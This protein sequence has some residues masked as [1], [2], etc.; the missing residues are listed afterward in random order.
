MSL[1]KKIEKKLRGVKDKFVDDIIPN[2]F[3]SG[4]KM[5]KTIRNLI[6]NELADVAV[7]LAP[8][9]APFNAPLAAA[10]RG[11]GRFDQRGSISDALKQAAATY[12]GGKLVGMIPGT[13]SY[14][15]KGFEGAK[16]LGSDAMSGITSIFKGGGKNAANEILK[17]SPKGMPDFS[18]MG[19]GGGAV[20]TGGSKIFDTIKSFGGK[21]KDK[22]LEYFL[23]DDKKFQM[24]DIGRFLGDPGKTIPLTM[25]ATYIKEKFFP[26]EDQDSFDAKFAEAMRKRGENV[27]SYLRRSGPFDPRRDPTKNPY[28]QD[29]IDQFA[30]DLT[31]EYRNVAADGGIMNIPRE[32]YLL[33]GKSI[34]RTVRPEP[35]SRG[36]AKKEITPDDI[37]AVFKEKFDGGNFFGRGSSLLPKKV[38]ATFTPQQA[39]P[40]ERA[41]DEEVRSTIKE[42]FENRLSGMP[43]SFRPEIKNNE[44]IM[45]LLTKGDQKGLDALM[46]SL[47]KDANFDRFRAATG[48]RMNYARGSEEEEMMMA[49]APDP[50]DE[51]NTVM[52][53]IAMEEFGRPLKDLTDDEIIQIEEMFEEM[54]GGQPLPEDPTKPINPF[55]PKP[56]GPALPDKL[57]AFMDDDYEREFMRLVGEFMEQ[58]FTQE[59]AIE[60]AR[61]ELARIGSKFMADGGRV[62]YARGSDTPEENAVQAAGIEGLDLNINPKGVT[63]LD[64]RE[65][66]G[67]IPPVGVKEKED[68][69]PAMLSNNE[70]VFTADAVRGMGD[71]DV[72]KGAE[73][74]YSMMKK[75]ENGGRV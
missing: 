34:A 52:E 17:G 47:L 44:E 41:S 5:K 70:F 1:F 43:A 29:E 11:I 30:D 26:D 54:S 59:E 19:T 65:T 74:M 75:L 38:S 8:F 42:F 14:F 61:N 72:D 7:D 27:G 31:I 16:A 73:R 49:S 20:E 69:I 2:E 68:D 22:G 36:A 71:G 37:M 23:G 50:M 40:A 33:G 21:A 45:E 63:E 51:R 57:M 64:M 48:G 62:N 24:G 28:T 3:K 32:N 53:N 18:G 46:T 25:I 56:T 35:G 55:A 6:P 13:E 9:V 12:G 10:M 67:F 58:G 15:G 66:G 4:E 39:L 60:A